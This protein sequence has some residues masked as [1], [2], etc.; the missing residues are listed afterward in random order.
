MGETRARM[1]R[2]KQG[3]Q[4]ACRRCKLGAGKV[5][6]KVAGEVAGEGADEGAGGRKSWGALKST[7][8]GM[9]A[10]EGREAGAAT[11]ELV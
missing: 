1:G 2:C 11:G 7:D 9:G 6:G 5:A 4:A 10:G 8:R 3:L